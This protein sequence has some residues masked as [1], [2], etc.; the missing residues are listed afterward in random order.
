MDC[1]TI[2][3]EP[4][5]ACCCKAKDISASWDANAC[6]N[7]I[8][9][10]IWYCCLQIH[11]IE[12]FHRHCSCVTWKEEDVALFTLVTKLILNLLTFVI[13]K[14][15]DINIY[16]RQGNHVCIINCVTRLVYR[17]CYIKM[18]FSKREVKK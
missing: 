18:G 1:E 7:A 8:L 5:L 6:L 12:N 11:G 2:R 13:A 10:N 4:T 3:L 9:N 14:E 17:V 15:K 16:E